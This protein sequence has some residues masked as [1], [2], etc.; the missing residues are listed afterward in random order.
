MLEIANRFALSGKPLYCERYGSGHI[1]ATY[2]L[3][4]STGREYIL[5]KINTHVFKDPEALMRNIM[6]VTEHL[7][8]NAAS[9][10]E[11]LTLVS[12]VDGGKWLNNNGDYWRM[13]EFIC[14]SMFFDKAENI[15][16]FRESAVAFGCFQRQLSD[17]PAHMLTETIPNF[18]NTPTRFETLKKAVRE[19]VCGRVKLVTKEIEFAYEREAYASTLTDLQANGNLPL[20]VTHNDTK[21][22]NVLFDRHTEKG[23]CVIDLD[24]VMPGLAVN[25]FGDSIRF[26][27]STAAEDERDLSKV[28][29]SLALFEAY[30]NGF[31]SS[32]GQ[33]LTACE[34]ESLRDG[35][36]MMTLECGVRF[37]TDYLAGDVYFHT[38]R[39]DHNLDRCRTQLKLVADMEREWNNMQAIVMRE[40]EKW[41]S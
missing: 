22:N 41:K 11:A 7:H 10:R 38:N 12:T 23:L 27:A 25:D 24:T 33:S 34:K 20:R 35:A 31:L 40:T 3:L 37:L 6:F 16:V 17:F 39:T 19:D 14:D 4:D 28:N 5:Q 15:A 1:N 26:G 18:H 32:C 30:T 9:S 2:L 36:K 29:F 21:L 8:K 13:Y